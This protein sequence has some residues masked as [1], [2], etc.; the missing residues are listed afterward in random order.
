MKVKHDQSEEA[1]KKLTGEQTDCKP[2]KSDNGYTITLERRTC[3]CRGTK[4]KTCPK[5]SM[6][7][8]VFKFR[9]FVSS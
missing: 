9:S 7:K 5:M 8:L 1:R 2:I 6:S 4:K 3:K